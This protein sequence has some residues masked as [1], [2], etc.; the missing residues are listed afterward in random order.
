MLPP[1]PKMGLSAAR[2]HRRRSVDERFASNPKARSCLELPDPGSA[3]AFG[4]PTPTSPQETIARR[5]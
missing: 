4:L 1:V 2:P 3:D 5:A